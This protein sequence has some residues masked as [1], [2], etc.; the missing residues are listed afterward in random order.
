[1]SAG[2]EVLDVAAGNGNFALAAAREGASAV[3]SDLSARMVELGRRRSEAEGYDVEWVEADAED[4]PFE[5]GRFDCAG[6]VFGA[7]FAPRPERVA[8]ELF[9]VVRPGGTV[10]MANWVPGGM[11]H[12]Q[13]EL[14]R[15]YAPPAPE[16]VPEP[17]DWG[18]EE[19]VAR[20]FEGLA[21]RLETDRRAV[22]FRFSSPEEA[23]D[24]FDR[25]APTQH[26]LRESI[27]E[28][29]YAALRDETVEL[30]REYAGD[31]GAIDAASEYLLIVARRRG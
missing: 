17:L 23:W 31:D 30:F 13:F 28:E 5:D 4:L 24:Y 25:V 6:S 21:G 19:I 10:G 8:A 14:T 27:G 9:R 18:D 1:V 12:R 7:M 29:E 20:R 22:P 2:Q 11:L 3:A 26:A 16:G 15:K